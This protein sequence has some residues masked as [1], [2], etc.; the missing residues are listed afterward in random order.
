MGII[1]GFSRISDILG[2]FAGFGVLASN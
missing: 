1:L 2:V